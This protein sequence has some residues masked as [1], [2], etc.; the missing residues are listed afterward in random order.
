MS[1]YGNPVML[2]GSGGGGSGVPTAGLAYV[3]NRSGTVAQ[4]LICTL[5]GRSFYKTYDAPAFAA[6]FKVGSVAGPLLVSETENGATYGQSQSSETFPPT[7][8]IVYNGVTYH[9]SASEY[10]LTASSSTAGFAAYLGAYDIS[11]SDWKQ[12]SATDLLNLVFGA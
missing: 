9:I 10:F 3:M 6:W 1:I 4:R 7:A 12:R 5:G 11:A 8:T 2:G